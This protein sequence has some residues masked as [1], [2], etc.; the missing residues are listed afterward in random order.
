MAAKRLLFEPT[1]LDLGFPVDRPAVPVSIAARAR[2]RTPAVGWLGMIVASLEVDWK[3]AL[4]LAPD[5]QASKVY[6]EA[7]S[8]AH[9]AGVRN[10]DYV[11]SASPSPVADMPLSELDARALPPGSDIYVKFHRPL[12][13]ARE[14]QTVVVRLRERPQPAKAPSWKK[15]EP[16]PFGPEVTRDDRKRFLS[17]MATHPRMSALGYRMLGRL[18]HHYDGPNGIYPSYAT[19]ARDVR[20]KRRQT[21]ITQIERLSWLGVVEV[22]KFAGVRTQGGFTNRFRVHWPEGWAAAGWGSDV[23]KSNVVKLAHRPVRR[24]K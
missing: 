4:E 9:R 23:A 24:P 19:L 6:V 8:P 5:G 21:A 7:R 3:L 22:V 11:L 18:V 2:P 12:W 1:Q 20:C 13:R 16:V 10:G 17:E 14:I 15:G